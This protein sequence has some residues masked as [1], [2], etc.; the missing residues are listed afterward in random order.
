[1]GAACDSDGMSGAYGYP[2]F[3]PQRAPVAVPRLVAAVLL[4]LAAALAVGGSFAALS[5]YRFESEFTPATTT[6]TTG[7]GQVQDPLP[8]E[9]LPTP[10]IQH[11]IP[12]TVAGVVALVAGLL[13]VLS[14][15]RADDPALA[16]S[17]GI[18]GGGLLIGV[19]SVIWLQLITIVRNVAANTRQEDVD[20][21]I[22]SSYEIG[23]GGYLILVAAIAALV[24]ALLVMVPRRGTAAPSP[25]QP[26]T[27]QFPALGPGAQPTWP[28]APQTW[29][30]PGPGAPPP[31]WGPPQTPPPYRG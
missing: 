8:T 11:G 29:P 1:M 15:R 18:A 23:L 16:R 21:G 6:T 10:I 9:P 26:G 7:W 3:G 24:A 25:A 22:R 5:I 20:A 12:L 31:G 13:L 28:A 27:G 30:Q 4:F 19:I 2:P 14:A 17:L